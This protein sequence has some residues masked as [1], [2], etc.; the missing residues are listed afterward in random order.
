MYAKG[1]V[2]AAELRDWLQRMEG[3]A[4][5]TRHSHGWSGCVQRTF[6]EP[7]PS[8]RRYADA[9]IAMFHGQARLSLRPLLRWVMTRWSIYSNCDWREAR[10]ARYLVKSC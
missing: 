4:F 7:V 5:L 8:K 2:N 6:T 1:A 9:G 3:R 10:R